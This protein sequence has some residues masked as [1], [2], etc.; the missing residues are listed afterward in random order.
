MGFI[1]NEG[2]ILCM[3]AICHLQPAAAEVT[4]GADSGAAEGWLVLAIPPEKWGLQSN[5]MGKSD[6]KKW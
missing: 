1:Q 5:S 4:S 3:I 2:L 6:Q